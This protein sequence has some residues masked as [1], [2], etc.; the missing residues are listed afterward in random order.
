MS[1]IWS[2]LPMKLWPNPGLPSFRIKHHQ[3]LVKVQGL[4]MELW[5]ARESEVSPHHDTPCWH[6]KWLLQQ[7]AVRRRS[8]GPGLRKAQQTTPW[9]LKYFGHLWTIHRLFILCVILKTAKDRSMTS[10]T[11]LQLF[12][13]SIAMWYFSDQRLGSVGKWEDWEACGPGSQSRV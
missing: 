11:H 10:M 6:R 3:A 12:T 9:T 2:L 13:A 8:F 4:R 7:C 5:M 1:I